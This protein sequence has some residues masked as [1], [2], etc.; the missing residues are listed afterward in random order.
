[1][2][3][4]TVIIT[5]FLLLCLCSTANADIGLGI[6]P[7]SITISD[8]FKG[9]TYERTI[10]VFNGGDETGNFMLMAE[11][12]CTDW[13][14][15]YKEDILIREITVPGKDKTKVLVKFDIPQ[16]IS[17]DDYTSTIYAQSVPDETS[18]GE[19][20]FAHAIIRIP[21]EVLIQVTGTQILN[22][23]VI[24]ITTTDIEIDYPLKIKLE[25]KNEGNVIAKPR[26]AVTMTKNGK[27]V[28]MFVHDKDGVKPDTKDTITVLWNTTQQRTGD[29]IVD[30]EVSLG[31]EILAN[32]NLP[33]KILPF[34][35]LTRQGELTY[36]TTEG[37]PLVGRMMKIL[38]DF[39]NTGTIDS[40]A[41]FKGE[42]YCD[43]EFID[44]IESN[45]ILVE[46][47]ETRRL[48]SYYKILSPGKYVV[49]GCVLYEGKETGTKEITFDVT[50]TNSRSGISGIP[51]LS[52]SMS[53][54]VII[55]ISIL[56]KK[57]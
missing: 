12:E 19:G 33:F 56:Y 49:E 57:R 1:M 14:S 52:G 46:I 34:G 16:E 17:N 6:S 45:E 32:E 24:S 53:I 8:A 44:V 26:I 21:S 9:G 27:L 39:E 35:T 2:K 7:A 28:D 47:G 18:S 20:A 4:T 40:R 54:I 11:G 37:D 23:T 10:T 31:G 51:G 36:L 41:T 50:S 43:G 55:L 22:G 25:F 29:Y 3:T 5:I 30:V 48:T 42:V 15:F 38:T 13:I